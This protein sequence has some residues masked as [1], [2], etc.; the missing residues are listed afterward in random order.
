[1]RVHAKCNQ[2]RVNANSREVAFAQIFAELDAASLIGSVMPCLTF[3]APLLVLQR[4]PAD[5]RGPICQYYSAYRL[6]LG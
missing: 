1:V 3:R 5:G 4:A 6:Q 2:M